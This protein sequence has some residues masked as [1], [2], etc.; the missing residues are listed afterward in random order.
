MNIA[1]EVLSTK[2]FI[3]AISLIIGSAIILI[4]P[5]FSN[6]LAI[7]LILLISLV[8]H[9]LQP[10][11]FFTGIERMEYLAS[12]TLIFKV[13]HAISIFLFI[14]DTSDT[15]IYALIVS[16]EQICIA[17]TG[18]IIMRFKFNIVLH[19]VSLS[20]IRQ[21]L[22]QNSSLFLNQLLPNLY[23]NTSTLLLGIFGG[24]AV[25]GVFGVLRKVT[26]LI[27]SIMQV[28]SSAFFP[29]INRVEQFAAR[30][31]KIQWIT[32]LTF[33]LLISISAPWLLTYFKVYSL[34]AFWSLLALT[35]GLIGLTMYDIYGLNFF[36]VR[37]QDKLVL[38]NTLIFSILGLIC[39]FPVIYFGGLL[40]AATI[41]SVTRVAIGSRLLWKFKHA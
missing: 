20:T 35:L 16:L 6:H 19:T 12:F 15:W 11:W 8:G 21:Q 26:N 14:D 4:T 36:I 30:F 10:N 5:I 25:T 18:L 33:C 38:R 31:A 32:T 29:A 13:A 22:K 24:T 40:G 7:F 41:V 1:S 2:A 3:L 28:I 27:E 23:N 39:A 9:A 34:E 17:V 37:N